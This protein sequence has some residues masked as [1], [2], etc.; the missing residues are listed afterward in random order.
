VA[1]MP[2]SHGN[3]NQ[4][5]LIP[6]PSPT[7]NLFLLPLLTGYCCCPGKSRRLFKLS[8][9]SLFL[10]H[11]PRPMNKP[12]RACLLRWPLLLSILHLPE[13]QIPLSP[14]RDPPSSFPGSNFLAVFQK[15]FLKHL[16]TSQKSLKVFTAKKK[17]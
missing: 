6:C 4:C 10:S 9:I 15:W 12:K 2:Q 13:V 5:Q 16:L 1:N 14:I 17:A 7:Q 11:L 3:V 8:S